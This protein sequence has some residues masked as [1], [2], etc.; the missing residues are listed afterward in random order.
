MA[1]NTVFT[2]NNNPNHNQHHDAHHNPTHHTE[3]HPKEYKQHNDNEVV[4]YQMAPRFGQ[5]LKL[6]WID[7][8]TLSLLLTITLLVWYTPHNPSASA[9]TPQIIFAKPTRVRDFA[10]N[11]QD[12]EVIYPQ[13]AYPHYKYILPVYGAVLIGIFGPIA[14]FLIVQGVVKSFWDFNNALFGL[15]YSVAMASIFTAFLKWLIGGIAPNFMDICKP[16]VPVPV[17]G[18][19]YRQIIY[20]S[21]ICT[22]NPELIAFALESFPSAASTVVFAGLIYLFLYL[23]AKLKVFANY[24]PRLWKLIALYLPILGA[25]LI[26]GQYLLDSHHHWYDVIAGAI[27]GTVFAISAYRMSYAAIW[28]FRFNHIALNR[29]MPLEYGSP[30]MELTDTAATCNAGWK[31]AEGVFGGAPC[32]SLMGHYKT[33]I[34]TRPGATSTYDGQTIHHTGPAMHPHTH[35]V[36]P[37]SPAYMRPAA[38][39]TS[40]GRSGGPSGELRVAAAAV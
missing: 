39:E 24:N 10:V 31:Y 30:T 14:V 8:L 1:G 38:E 34:L 7:L 21:S 33:H 18:R 13:F 3:K 32:D 5:W 22:G 6:S 28:D 4:S 15:L 35:T 19:G 11:F 23:N 27:I 26:S 16:L 12:G 25:V 2:S 36:R 29:T 9:N 20:D 37:A 17:Q 40:Y